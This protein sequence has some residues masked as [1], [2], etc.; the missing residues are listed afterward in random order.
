MREKVLILCT[1]NS[2]RSQMAEGILRHY[3]HKRFEVFSAGTYPCRVNEHAV[4]VMKE[5]GIDIAH[6]RSKHITEFAGEEFSRIITLCDGAKHL[7]PLFPGEGSWHHW[8][9]PDPPH[10]CG[11]DDWVLAE[12]RKV[13]D[14]I[15]EK[16]RA[17]GLSGVFP[18]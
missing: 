15:H 12:F 10:D 7:C 2:C 1:G 3:G 4:R 14:M 11:S 16:F 8:P 6:Q 17:V 13:R 9:F 18:P 5:L